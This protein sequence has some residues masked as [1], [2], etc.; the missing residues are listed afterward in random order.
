MSIE[1][2]HVL[3]VEDQTDLNRL[4]TKYIQRSG[5]QTESVFSVEEANQFLETHNTDV[6][7]MD[8]N[9]GDG[10]GQYILDK[11]IKR[12]EFNHIKIVIVS[13]TLYVTERHIM[14]DRVNYALIKPVSPRELV[15]LVKTLWQ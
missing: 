1:Q 3:I 11:I 13:G 8:L 5:F 7:V 14:L 12:P 10:S 9:L 15:T 2:K 6:I 4:Y